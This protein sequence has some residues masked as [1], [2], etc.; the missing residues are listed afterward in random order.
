MKQLIFTAGRRNTFN[1]T[2]PY[3]LLNVQRMLFS[4]NNN[5]NASIYIEEDD[6][7]A[8]SY[9]IAK[10]KFLENEKKLQE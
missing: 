7:R 4:K 3:S 8:Q 9:L 2:R 10:A 1:T 6:P 5:K